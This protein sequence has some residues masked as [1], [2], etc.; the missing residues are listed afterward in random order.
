[1]EIGLSTD[2]KLVFVQENLPRPID[3]QAKGDQ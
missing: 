1:M 2:R 3:D